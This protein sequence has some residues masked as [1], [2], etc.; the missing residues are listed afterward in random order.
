MPHMANAL[1]LLQ[2]HPRPHTPSLLPLEVHL[3]AH[4]A[5]SWAGDRRITEYLG[6]ERT[7]GDHQGRVS[8]SMLHRSTSMLVWKVSR[9]RDSMTFLGCLFQ[10]SATL[11]VKK[12]FLILKWNFPSFS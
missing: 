11:N 12:L 7:S 9:E 5:R 3:S 4:R 8:Y 6:L 1:H 10:F 2:V